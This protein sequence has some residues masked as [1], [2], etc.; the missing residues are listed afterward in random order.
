MKVM[1]KRTKLPSTEVIA[2]AKRFFESETGMNV[3]DET[4]DCCVEFSSNLGF[5]IVQ[6]QGEDREREVVLKT[7]EYE[8]QIQEFL[9]RI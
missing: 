3:I 4:E 8:Y 9:K 7:R 5:V 1:S 2:R 6:L